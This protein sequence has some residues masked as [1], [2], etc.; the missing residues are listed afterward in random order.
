MAIMNADWLHNPARDK[1]ITVALAGM[2]N[3]PTAE[4]CAWFCSSLCVLAKLVWRKTS[5]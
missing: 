2:E 4:L 1:K 3:Q 5:K